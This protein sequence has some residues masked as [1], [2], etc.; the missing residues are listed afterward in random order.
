MGFWQG[1]VPIPDGTSDGTYHIWAS[2][3]CENSNGE[4]DR[5]HYYRDAEFSVTNP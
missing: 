5:F 4:T 1:Q 2:C 3:H